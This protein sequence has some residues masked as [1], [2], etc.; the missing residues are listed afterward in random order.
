MPIVKILSCDGL[1]LKCLW[2]RK[3]SIILAFWSF[4]EPLRKYNK[5]LDNISETINVFKYWISHLVLLI[6]NC[7]FF[8]VVHMILII[9]T[10]FT[11]HYDDK[12]N[13]VSMKKT[14]VAKKYL[15]SYLIVDLLAFVPQ[16]LRFIKF[17]LIKKQLGW[18]VPFL[19]LSR[20]CRW[21]FIPNMEIFYK[22]KIILKFIPIGV[23]VF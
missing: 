3:R 13:I 14:D 1:V 22:I 20:Y 15:L 21:E 2:K 16:I 12:Q 18:L 8:L 17:S 19:I 23:L 6:F 9:V 5:T 7:Q 11:G 4:A 10:F